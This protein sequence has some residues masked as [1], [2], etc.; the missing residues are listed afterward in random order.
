[1]KQHLTILGAT[2]SIG[3]ST[4]EV[5][6]RH[7][8]CYEIHALTAHRNLQGLARQCVDFRPRL[9]VVPEA[10]QLDELARL[11]RMLDPHCPTA[12][13][14][15]EGALEEVASAS[16]VTTVMAAIVGA[17]GLASTL[18][19]ARSGKKILLANKES[20]V[21]SGPLMM[22]AVAQGGACLLPVD[23]EH[24]AIFQCWPNGEGGR[25]GVEKILLTASGG[26]FLNTPLQDL[27]TV[28]PEQACQHPKWR[29]GKKISVDSATMMNKGLELIEACWLFGLPPEKVEIVIHPQSLVHSLVGFSDGSLLAQLGHT[30]M[31]I[32]IAHALA[33]PERQ[34][35]GVPLLD[36]TVAG[37]LTFL[38]LERQRFPAV[39]LA[40][41]AMQAGGTGPTLLNAANEVAVAAFL[42]GGLSFRAITDTI[43]Q[44]LDQ[45]PSQA[46]TTLEEV[47][48]ADRRAR[49]LTGQILARRNAC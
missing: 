40:E 30:D 25:S 34:S 39:A 26:P 20:L 6:R 42:A 15:G 2:G 17:A 37:P 41:Q 47:N 21:M 48:E 46:C 32:P 45:L 13:R 3:M 4:L 27:E 11:L 7:P 43:A 12:L 36:L 9:A 29:M 44:V 8:E 5:V 33:Y 38:P 31:R 18:A 49:H 22:Q 35:S 14:A 24:N 16:E 1:M 23:S 19:A 28:T 10:A